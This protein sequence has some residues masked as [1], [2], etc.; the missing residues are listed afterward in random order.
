ME[1][2]IDNRIIS[3][4]SCPCCHSPLYKAEKSNSLLCKGA[5]THCYDISSS[6]HINFALRHIGGG[7]SKEAVLSRR[8]FLDTGAY[9]P[10]A[11]AIAGLASELL[12]KD[13]LVVDAGCGEGYYSCEIAKCGLA[14]SGFDLS[15]DAVISAS[16]RAKREGQFATS[17][18]LYG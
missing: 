2:A 7:D 6:G 18:R 9:A 8:D 15:K 13:A 10:V 14:V 3:G 4:L 1:K 12:P 17:H 16:K 11:E 5:K